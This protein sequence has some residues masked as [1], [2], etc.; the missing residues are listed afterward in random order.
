MSSKPDLI[1]C[2]ELIL[3]IQSGGYSPSNFYWYSKPIRI[4]K[5][6][7]L[8]IENTISEHDDYVIHKSE[9]KCIDIPENKI[10]GETRSLVGDISQSYSSLYQDSNLPFEVPDILICSNL[11]LGIDM[12]L[13][14]S[15]TS[16]SG[17][18]YAS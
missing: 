7:I 4:P 3:W 6:T 16:D 14:L 5:I 13:F 10:N 2:Q 1:I 15:S 9:N 8:Y 18:I 11:G 17:F 12:Y